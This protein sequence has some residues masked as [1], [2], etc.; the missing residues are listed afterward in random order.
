LRRRRVLDKDILRTGFI[1]N[2]NQQYIDTQRYDDG[3]E[4]VPRVY[5]AY[6]KEDKKF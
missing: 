6:D 3:A 1:Q 2:V 5:K 4:K